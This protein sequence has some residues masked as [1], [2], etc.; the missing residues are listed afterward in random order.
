M[1]AHEGGCLCGRV[2][3]RLVGEP[4][5]SGYCHCRMCQRNSGAPVVA[6]VTCDSAAF[7]WIA[8]R[9][10]TY[11][12]SARAQRQFCADCGSYLVFRS[13]DFPDEVSIN[14]ASFD[15]PN[16]FPPRLHIFTASRIPWFRTDDALP[17]YEA[18]GPR[19]HE[20]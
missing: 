1:K 14:T 17:E 2:R 7:S 15:E 20:S 4:R 16:D 3:F 13:D 6:W 8:G 19:P 9:A 10:Q 18:Y 12:S 11:A 5:D